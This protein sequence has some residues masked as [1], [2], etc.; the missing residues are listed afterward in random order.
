MKFRFIAP[1]SLMSLVT[2]LCLV[3]YSVAVL[4]DRTVTS[5]MSR[6]VSVDI[7]GVLSALQLFLLSA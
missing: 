2:N 3:D 4:Y 1:F 6:V 7:K 5:W